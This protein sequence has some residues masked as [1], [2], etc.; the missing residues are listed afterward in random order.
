MDETISVEVGEDHLAAFRRSPKIAIAELIW[1]S[2]DADA[3]KVT[4][5]YE[6]NALDGIDAVIVGDDGT[7]MNRPPLRL[8]SS[9]W[10]TA[11][12]RTAPDPGHREP[13]RY[14]GDGMSQAAWVPS[15]PP[16]PGSEP[17]QQL[18]RN[19]LPAR[20]ICGINAPR[21]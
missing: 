4:V 10:A 2:L 6:P 8:K 1:N 15:A 13:V 11:V 9:P 14:A 16:G 18:F 3:T 7:G 12:C 20:L 19:R 17:W 5:E 21:R